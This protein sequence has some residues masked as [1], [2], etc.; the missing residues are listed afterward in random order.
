MAKRALEGIKV[1][2][3]AAFAAGPGIG[4]HLAD[5]GAQV[6]RVESRSRPD[7]FRTHYPPFKDN[8]PGLNRSGCFSF[9]NNNKYSVTINL[10]VPGA[11]EL[12]KRLVARADIV[13]ENMTPGTIGRLG[14]GYQELIKVKPDLIM[15]STCNQGQTGPHASHPGFGSHLS[16]LSGFSHFTGYPG[17]TPLLLYGPYI[18]FIGEG[19]GL[20]CILAALDYRRRTGKGTFIDCAQY[21][22]G[23]QF[24]IPA[25]LHFTVNGKIMER[26]GNR[27][28]AAAPCGAF[29][30]QGDDQWCALSVFADGEWQALRKVM[31]NP[32]WALDPKFDT[33][34]GRKKHEDELEEKIAGWTRLFTREELMEKLQNVGIRA[35]IVNTMGGLFSDL[36]LDHRKFWRGIN[37]AEMGWHHYKTGSFFLT[38]TPPEVTMPAPCLG[39]HNR[40]VFLEVLGMAETE[41]E[42]LVSRGVVE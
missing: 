39:E 2:E 37:H 18:D 24:L 14:L 40:Y 35:G 3:F 10:K 12:A 33:V 20:I 4:K 27:H 11:V 26:M 28:P 25:M 30:C 22:N 41:F 6:I 8:K 19:Y 15:L 1:V 16:S 31:G 36:Q 21:E 9:F 23:V 29:P 5:H 7:G 13:I 34:L 32:S 38:K 17:K 42:E